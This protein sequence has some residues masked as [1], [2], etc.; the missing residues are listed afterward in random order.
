[1]YRETHPS[2]DTGSYAPRH[3][4]HVASDRTGSLALVVRTGEHAPGTS[5]GINFSSFEN[6]I[7]LNNAGQI[8]VVGRLTNGNRGLWATDRNGDLQYVACEGEQLE[9][10]SGEFRTVQDLGFFGETGNGDGRA[11]GFNNLGQLAF[12]A[13][14]TDGTSG[15]FVSNAVAHLPGDFNH[16]GT[17]DAADYVVCRKGLGTTNTQCRGPALAAGLRRTPQTCRRPARAE[18]DMP[19]VYWVGWSEH[20]WFPIRGS[21]ESGISTRAGNLLTVVAGKS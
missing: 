13:S 10:A 19:C 2:G 1:M 21:A 5:P 20:T 11:S 15:I 17:V 6:L 14:F 18:C 16:D 12:S 9:L 8:A 3:G 7:V 4:H